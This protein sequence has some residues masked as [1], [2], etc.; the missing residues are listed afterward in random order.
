VKAKKWARKAR[1]IVVHLEGQH[2][3]N[4]GVHL[5]EVRDA[6]KR[7]LRTRTVEYRNERPALSAIMIDVQA[8]L[9]RNALYVD[10]G[11]YQFANEGRT[12]HAS[13]SVAV[14]P[15]RP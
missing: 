3:L 7:V 11:S 13:V 5:I 8:R 4:R 6:R 9:S 15:R 2:D 14:L 12:L 1:T 10:P